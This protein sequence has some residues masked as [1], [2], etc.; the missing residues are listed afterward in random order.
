MRLSLGVLIVVSLAVPRPM[1]AQTTSGLPASRVV[2]VDANLVGAATPLGGSRSFGSY[3]LKF[4]EVG[5]FRATYPGPSRPRL[6]PLLDLGGGIMVSRRVGIGLGYSREVS[7]GVVTLEASVPHPAFFNAPANDTGATDRPLSRRESAL[8]LSVV[9]VPLRTSRNEFRI[10]GGPSYFT[11]EA[12]MVRDVLYAQ[13]SDPLTPLNSIS[14]D[15]FASARATARDVGFH[16][17]AEYTRF[18]HRVIG[19]A[20][21]VKYSF[22]TVTLDREPLT[23]IVQDI[24]VGHTSVFLGVRYRPGRSPD[25]K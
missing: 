20:A 11:Y 8:H 14:I 2:F 23:G 6:F 22:A 21:G 13:T 17:G 9:V 25:N 16:A 18:I 10:L 7:E 1:A 15:G 19:I 4:G 24:R 5:T 3:F 12:D